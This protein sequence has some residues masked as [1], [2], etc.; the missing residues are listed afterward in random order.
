M[1][2]LQDARDL[3]NAYLSGMQNSSGSPHTDRYF[4][5]ALRD[6]RARRKAAILRASRLVGGGE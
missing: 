3:D 1:A 2:T 6:C 5:A 4:D